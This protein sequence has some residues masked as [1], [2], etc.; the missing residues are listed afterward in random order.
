MEND[1]GRLIKFKIRDLL[2]TLQLLHSHREFD[3]LVIST[4]ETQKPQFFI[5]KLNL[6]E[7]R[8]GGQ[9]KV[10]LDGQAARGPAVNRYQ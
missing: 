1:S 10:P 9:A 7:K 2:K 3:G 5:T 6:A 8:P 4:E